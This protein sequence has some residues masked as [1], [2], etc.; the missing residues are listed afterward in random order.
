MEYYA[1]KYVDDLGN[2]KKQTIKEHLEGTKAL[3]SQFAKE[4]FGDVVEFAAEHHDI[5]KYAITFQ[6]RLDGSKE[7]FEHSICGAIEIKKQV[8]D[9]DVIG[10]LLQYCIAGHHSGLP[11]GG[12]K[13][14]PVG[15]TLYGRLKNEKN[16][17]G[18]RDYSYYSNE[19]ESNVPDGMY[20]REALHKYS[21]NNDS[22]KKDYLETFAFFTRYVFSC[23]T[24][25]DFIDTE[26]FC[27]P[28]K[29]R[30]GLSGDFK[31]ALEKLNDRLSSF[32]AE[33]EVQKARSRLQNQAYKNMF[34][35]GKISILN[36]PTGS[37]KTLC[38]IKIAIEKILNS[39]DKDIK[40]IIYVIPYTSI[41]EQTAKEFNDIFGDCV[42]ILQ[43]HSNYSFDDNSENK[44]TV[45]K[46]RNAC[47]NWDAPLIVTTSVQFFQSLYHYKGSGLRKLHNMADSII[48]F[49]EIHLI[50]IK[51]LQPCLRGIGYIT[52]YLNSKAILLSAT[53]PN[54]SELFEKYLPDVSVNNL[55][56]DRTDF[57]VFNKC[58]YTFMGKTDYDNVIMKAGEF[59]NSLIIVNTKKI[60]QQ[61]Y[62]K[63]S[64]KKYH[65]SAYMTPDHRSDIIEEIKIALANGE[66]ITVV[67]TSLIEAGVDLDFKA[68]FR[69]V[70]GLDSILQ[71]G[72]RCNRE[73]KDKNGNVFIFETDESMYEDIKIPINISN[74]LLKEYDDITSKECIEEYYNRIF[75]YNEKCIRESSIAEFMQ[76][77]DIRCMP[78][79]SYAEQFKYINDETIGIVVT[80]NNQI[81][82]ELWER[83]K[84]G[85][86]DLRRQLQRY[87]VAIQQKELDNALMLGA[88]DD[89]GTGVYRLTSE[90]YY[91][92]QVGLNFNSSYDDKYICS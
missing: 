9:S 61:V 4:E 78:F 54:Y 82:K 46:L 21:T 33:T 6:R 85:S 57:S 7:K 59:D 51:Y 52:K 74:S 45:E 39:P 70:T 30:G 83:F 16:Y 11:D 29:I 68:V 58:S 35:D 77:K 3:A 65:L 20:L 88:V 12:N 64:G 40:R 89:E 60:A 48:I 23:L 84:N 34:N 87:T 5:G 73:G 72:G 43:H 14:N 38:S 79:R 63:V 31:S 41:I 17:V 86:K 53:M 27:D 28:D 10:K 92:M 66:K 42:Q 47:E 32:K 22:D 1:H 25:A 81:A 49:D 8:R 24:D 80:K 44:T 62:E 69:E 56:T 18:A 36:M 67:S 55:I 91:D 13:T 71:S 50:P 76:T 2:E 15:S 37:G 90:D 19:I 75:K 26:R